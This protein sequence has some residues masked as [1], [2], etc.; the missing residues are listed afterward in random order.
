MSSS[1]N[2]LSSFRFIETLRVRSASQYRGFWF[3]SRLISFD[4]L[5]S[6]VSRLVFDS[7]SP[8]RSL[9]KGQHF[10]FRQT[11]LVAFSSLRLASPRS[12]WLSELPP[13]PPPPPYGRRRF[14]P[15]LS[16]RTSPSRPKSLAFGTTF[17]S[18]LNVFTGMRRNCP[19]SG[20][21]RVP[22]LLP[23]LPRRL[24]LRLLRCW[25]VGWT[26]K[27]LELLVGWQR[28]SLGGML[29]RRL[30]RPHHHPSWWRWVWVA[31]FR[32]SIQT[33]MWRPLW[34]VEGWRRTLWRCLL[35]WR[36]LR[37]RCLSRSWLSPWLTGKRLPFG[38]APMRL[39]GTLV[40]RLP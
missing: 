15:V 25:G 38:V 3:P 11:F 12:L 8:P 20:R 36:P 21:P 14:G 16:R 35:W 31:R 28:S 39:L 29:R 34:T 24:L 5:K 6:L 10:F 19:L 7:T 13:P 22:R 17:L 1:R 37:R 18:F 23:I 33:G 9:K 2:H 30:S 32:I 4:H 27:V 26:L 40:A